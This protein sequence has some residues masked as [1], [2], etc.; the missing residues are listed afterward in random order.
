LS[1]V[2]TEV[3][4]LAKYFK[5]PNVELALDPEFSMKDGAKPGTE[6]GT[7]DATD[8]NFAANYL[9]GIVRAN[10]LPPKVLI[11]H[12]FTQDMVT[13]YQNITPLPEVQIV[14]DMDGWGSPAKKTNTYEQFIALQPVQFTGFKL[15]YVNDLRAPS[16]RMM[17][18]AELLKL[19]PQPLFI[20][21]Q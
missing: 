8:I 12:R 14:M 19:T 15:F 16:T 13:N 17:T 18:D 7:M 2:Q 4:L 5:L 3:P 21:Y 20:Q 6:I 10:N 1:N 11:V 9:A